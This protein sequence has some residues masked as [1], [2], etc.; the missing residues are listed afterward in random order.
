M[1]KKFEVKPSLFGGC[2]RLTDRDTVAAGML[3]QILIRSDKKTLTDEHGISGW[4]SMTR[5][6]W[7]V[8]TGYSRHQH[9]A[10]IR[11]LKKKGLIKSRR[12]KLSYKDPYSQ[13]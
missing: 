2:M 11:K 12:R 3:C 13:T 10:A 9:D 4:I 6:M 7:M 8:V 5:D 1:K